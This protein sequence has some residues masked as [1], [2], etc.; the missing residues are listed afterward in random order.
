MKRTCI[1]ILAAL[2]T[3]AACEKPIT[4]NISANPNML[5]FAPEGGSQTITLSTNLAW[6]ASTDNSA[7]SISPKSGEASDAATITV[8]MPAS[9]TLASV[10]GTITFQVT[11]GEDDVLEGGL[12]S[13]SVSVVQ[14]GIIAS[15]G[16]S[17]VAAE[18]TYEGAAVSTTITANI[19]WT[20]TCSTEG[21]TV[22]PSTGTSG[23]TPVTI[24][25]PESDAS[26]SIEVLF[27]LNDPL[28]ANMKA[29]V[30]IAQSAPAMELGGVSYAIKKMG[31]GRWWMVENMR[32]VPDGI[33]PSSDP[34][35][36]SNVWYPYDIVNK[37]PMTD[38]E[39]VAKYGYLYNTATACCLD[40][41]TEENAASYEKTQGICAEG[42][43]I[44]SQEE[45]NTLLQVY[46]DAET[47]KGAPIPA[48]NE[49]GFNTEL[50]GFRMKNTS[51]NNGTYNILPGYIITSTMYSYK[52]NADTGA[53]TSMNKAAMKTNNATY[54]RFTVANASN[55]GGSNVRCVRDN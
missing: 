6:S 8:T 18:V 15:I 39:S 27:A 55:F 40:G 48:L 12:S 29:T 9:S 30:A 13:V 2:V 45:M 44:P 11:P 37:V 7:I 32:Y 10:S 21:V 47:Q 22:S 34:A 46:W 1:L 14:N 38:D 24:T 26:R 54:Q 42:W 5:T 50:G 43:H 51:T 28:A 20:A 41:I 49:A 3:L 35:V 16:A 25:V 52:V 4:P 33:T 23:Q 17:P 19:P 36:E 53:I 31:D